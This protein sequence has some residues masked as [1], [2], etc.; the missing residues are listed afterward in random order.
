MNLDT[1]AEEQGVGVAGRHQD[2][3]NCMEGRSWETK[4][5]LQEELPVLEAFI[6]I[7]NR[8][9]ALKMVNSLIG[10]CGPGLMSRIRP[11]SSNLK[12]S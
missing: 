1:H 2:R 7:R 3:W 5:T 10:D 11:D 4:L 12:M 9:T 8:L 6:G